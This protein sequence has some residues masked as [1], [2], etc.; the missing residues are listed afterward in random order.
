MVTTLTKAEISI[1]SWPKFSI[2]ATDPVKIKFMMVS[3]EVSGS[4]DGRL[5]LPSDELT[6]LEWQPRHHG[7]L[8]SRKIDKNN[9]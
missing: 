2:S 7:T 1:Y 5:W 9:D 3:D 4:R 8:G 6:W